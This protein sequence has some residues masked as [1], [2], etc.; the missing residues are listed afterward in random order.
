MRAV[1]IHH[2]AVQTRDLGAS[3]RFYEGVLGLA[4][5]ARHF[6]DDGRERS[7]WLDAGGG[8]LL[9]LERASPTAR[10]P[11]EEPF[12]SSHAGWHVV[13]LGIQAAERAQWEARL[14]HAR[15]DVV[16][17][18]AFT[19]YVRDPDGNRV[20]LSHYPNAV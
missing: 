5:V 15:V 9:M 16:H 19:L 12:V 6:F 8:T 20:G 18:S 7:V 3:E 1:G 10:P 14:E 13:A 2:V 4:V 17:R 11:G